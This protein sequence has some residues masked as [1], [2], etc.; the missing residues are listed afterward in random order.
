MLALTGLRR[1]FAIDVIF[2]PVQESHAKSPCFGFVFDPHAFRTTARTGGTWLRDRGLCRSVQLAGAQF[3]DRTTSGFAAD[4]SRPR[5][6]KRTSLWGA[7][8][9]PFA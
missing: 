8:Q 9:F 1:V 7:F 4:Q 5:I 6:R 2:Y 3:P